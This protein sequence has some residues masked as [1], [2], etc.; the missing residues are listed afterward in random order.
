MGGVM[1]VIPRGV[2]NPLEIDL[3]GAAGTFETYLTGGRVAGRRG[4]LSGAISAD[5]RESEGHVANSAYRG[6]DVIA[7]GEAVVPGGLLLTSRAKY[8][9]GYKEEPLRYTDDPSA[10]SD[11]WNEYRRGSLDVG[12]ESVGDAHKLSASYFRNFGEHRFS[13]GWHSEDVTDG[14]MINGR[15]EPAGGLEVSGG[16]DYRVQRG[17]L[18]GTPEAQWDKWEAGIYVNAEYSFRER[19]KVSAGTRFNQDEASGNGISP[20]FGLVWRPLDGTSLRAVASHGFRSPQLNELYMFPSSNPG[21]EA[22]KMWNYE[23]GLRQKIPGG[24]E[25]DVSA[26]RMDGENLIELSGNPAPP[27]PMMFA[28]TGDFVFDGMEVAL[29]GRWE[30]GMSANVSYSKLDPGRWT[31]GR[32]GTKVDFRISYRSGRWDIRLSGSHVGDY[33]AGNDST[34]PIASFTFADIYGEAEIA[35]GFSAFA[36]VGNI[37]DEDYLIYTDLPGGRAG[38]YEMP[39]RNVTMGLKYGY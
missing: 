1:N 26:Y 31:Q 4:S 24:L 3:R 18:P 5:R 35:A 10:V 19:I 34:D 14:V 11:T 13:D 16:G 22:E 30:A 38:L 2:R 8:F 28:N 17:E 27:P 12:L 15:T 21:L 23:A 7:S 32:P 9:D 20:S 37:L 29:S 33:Y 6:T 39:G 25:I 36:G